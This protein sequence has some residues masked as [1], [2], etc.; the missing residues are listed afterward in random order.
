MKEKLVT[1]LSIISLFSII[2]V[3]GCLQQEPGAYAKEQACVNS[4]G[5]VVTSSCC[6]SAGDFP[7]LCLIGACGCSPDNS[8]EVKTCD[9]GEGGCFNGTSCL[10]LITSFD[11][12]VAAGYPVMG[13]YP[14]Q[15]RTPNGETFVEESCQDGSG[16]ILTLADAMEIAKASECGDR[17]VV[18]CR[19]PEGY[20]QEGEACNPECYYSE[21]RCLMPSV[22][23]EKS[24][25][26]NDYTGTWWIDLNIQQTGCSPACV[27]NITSR[28]AEIN[29]RCTGLLPPEC[30]DCPQL[31]P[32]APGFCENGT[33]VSPEPDECGCTGPP[34]CI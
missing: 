3:S 7:N 27:I 25:Q 33:I 12:C 16:S 14:R 23:C 13:S 10:S 9:C 18:E 32:P 26:C 15:C 4:G 31:T 24:Y 20:V 21:P 6:L 29:W 2:I 5:S 8:H 1:S 11:G 28:Q 34:Q 22:S 30:G 19:C 17:L